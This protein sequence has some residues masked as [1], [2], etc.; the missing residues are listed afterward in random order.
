[1][2]TAVVIIRWIIV[3][4]V[5]V[6]FILIITLGSTGTV[7]VTKLTN[8]EIFKTWLREGEVYER[9]VPI[10]VD[11]LLGKIGEQSEQAPPEAQTQSPIGT[12]ISK[13][14]IKAEAQNVFPPAWIQEQAEQ[15]IDSFFN[16]VHGTSETFTFAVDLAPIKENGQIVLAKLFKK[17]VAELSPC[18]EIGSLDQFDLFKATC[19]PPNIEKE[20]AYRIIDEK[21]DTI[22]LFK[23]TMITPESLNFN[24]DN[25]ELLR[26]ILSF[27]QYLPATLIILAI[28]VTLLTFGFTPGKRAKYLVSGLL[29]LIPGILL[30]GG[31]GMSRFAGPRL[32]TALI[33]RGG[34]EIPESG[35]SLIDNLFKISIAD[36]SAYLIIAGCVTAGIGAIFFV[37]SSLTNISKNDA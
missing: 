35:L 36:I 26:R 5:I 31:G 4:T 37:L 16:F 24:Q 17:R 15:V 9:I 1:M 10:A 6:P 11:Q 12:F 28:L 33:K 20:E 23:E 32:L 25:I 3:G 7:L 29:W 13:E 18:S 8:G 14:E 27:A 22:P 21:I 30:I 34:N 2:K 19:F